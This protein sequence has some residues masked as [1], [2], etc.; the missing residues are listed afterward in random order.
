MGAGLRSR[1]I[2]GELIERAAGCQRCRAYDRSVSG[3]MQAAHA[4]YA[5]SRDGSR[6]TGQCESGEFGRTP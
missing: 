3:G 1:H 4:E 2:G 6:R 5:H